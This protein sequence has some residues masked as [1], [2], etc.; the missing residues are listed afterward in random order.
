MKHF[1]SLNL[2]LLILFL[3]PSWAMAENVEVVLIDKLDGNLSGY[4]LDIVGGG[5]NIN[6]DN[7]LQAHTCYS[8]RGELGSDQAIDSTGITKGVFRLPAFDVCAT[9]PSLDSG[10]TVSLEEC[11]NSD[12]QKFN[13]SDNGNIS[14]SKDSNMCLT[15]GK[16]SKFGRNGTS[17]HQIKSLS[18]EPCEPELAAYQQWRFRSEAD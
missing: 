10:T 1:R 12:Q 16:E 11:N 6:P 2:F 5:Q 8:Y 4:C 17:P 9:L 3:L 18:L 13:F 14:P 7:G 15:V